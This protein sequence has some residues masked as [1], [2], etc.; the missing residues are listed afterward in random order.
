MD[1]ESTLRNGKIV[2][3]HGIKQKNKEL[4]LALF[5]VYVDDEFVVATGIGPGWRYDKVRNRMTHT[6]QFELEDAGVPSDQLTARVFTNIANDLDSDIKMTFDCPSLNIDK[7]MPVL[8]LK[9]WMIK[10]TNGCN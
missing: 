7:K 5:K 10:D 8:D 3:Q 4:K 6:K 2:I 9:V 1:R